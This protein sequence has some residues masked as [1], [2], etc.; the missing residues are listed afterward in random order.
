MW[1]T[2]PAPSWS[3][4]THLSSA[5]ARSGRSRSAQIRVWKQESQSHN[6]GYTAVFG[7]V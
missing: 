4:R 6:Q 1:G 3:S 7:A 5:T 2:K